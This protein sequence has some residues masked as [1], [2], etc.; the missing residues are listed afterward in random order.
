VFSIATSG[1]KAITSGLFPQV[2]AIGLDTHVEELVGLLFF[3]ATGLFLIAR[4]CIAVVGLR[5]RRSS[6]IDI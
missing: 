4:G 1:G 5:K 3:V 2:L 6:G